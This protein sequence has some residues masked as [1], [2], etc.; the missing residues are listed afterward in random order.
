M[1]FQSTGIDRETHANNELFKNCGPGWHPAADWK[2]AVLGARLRQRR[3]RQPSLQ[4]PRLGALDGSVDRINI[5]H[6]LSGQPLLQRLNA[7]FS[8]NR[9]AIRPS[10]PSTQNPG[11]IRARLS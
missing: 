6:A 4:V 1:S 8:V 7:L 11:V 10:S 9:N 2:S 5:L 3:L